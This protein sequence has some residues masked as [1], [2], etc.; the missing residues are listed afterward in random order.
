MLRADEIEALRDAG[1]RLCSLGHNIL[2]TETA[3]IYG[4]AVL[5]AVM[6]EQRPDQVGRRQGRLGDQTTHPGLRTQAARAGVG[7]G[8]GLKGHGHG[9]GLKQSGGRGKR[10]FQ[11]S[12]YPFSPLIPADA[13]TECFGLGMII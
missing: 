10:R 3:A 13:G 8:G 11:A 1:A 12:A 9:R 2:R 7:E 4:L 6:D 5:G